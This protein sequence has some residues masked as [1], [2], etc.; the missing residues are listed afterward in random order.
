MY[1]GAPKDNEN[2]TIHAVE[3]EDV[4]GHKKRPLGWSQLKSLHVI[5]PTLAFED[6]K[7][8]TT[9]SSS[10]RLGLA[11]SPADQA[12]AHAI[13][14]VW[15]ASHGEGVSIL[16]KA[17]V[18]IP[19]YSSRSLQNA[20]AGSRRGGTTNSSSRFVPASVLAARNREFQTDLETIQGQ[21]DSITPDEI[22]DIVRNIQDPEHAGVSL[23]QLRVVSR[24][25]I[26]VNDC[27]DATTT[28]GGDTNEGPAQFPSV[29]V[30][31]T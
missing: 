19:K 27:M 16:R 30:R 2:P 5:P 20:T 7:D 17:G 28:S 11:P 26:D 23:E 3:E 21:R 13:M 31:F 25:Q 1:A 12:V 15:E 18:G 24:G 10:N 9:G 14:D 4:V 29:T 6:D 8:D 22:F